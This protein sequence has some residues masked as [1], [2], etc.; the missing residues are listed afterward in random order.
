MCAL[1]LAMPAFS[2]QTGP[3]RITSTSPL[4]D[5]TAQTPYN[6]QLTATGGVP[7][8]VWRCDCSLPP[9]LNF[10]PN[11][12]IS[13]TPTMAGS[14]TLSVNVQDQRQGTDSTRIGLT[15]QPQPL[16]ITSGSPLPL[17]TVGSRYSASFAATRRPSPRSCTLAPGGRVDAALLV[18]ADCP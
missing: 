5:A 14:Y 16:V 6:Q 11:G 7:P 3:L 1:G 12:V 2:Q 13:G 18:A 17:G 10:A 9:G 15:V 4:P 8:Y